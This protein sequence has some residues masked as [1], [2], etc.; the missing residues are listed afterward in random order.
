MLE[1]L[2]VLDVKLQIIEIKLN[3]VKEASLVTRPGSQCFKTLHSLGPSLILK[4]PIGLFPNDHLT[5]I[6]ILFTMIG[7][8][9]LKILFLLRTS[10]IELAPGHKLTLVRI[11][12]VNMANKLFQVKHLILVTTFSNT[13]NLAN[14][15]PDEKFPLNYIVRTKDNYVYV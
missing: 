6:Y 12:F 3:G 13:V 14:S 11:S 8:G 1:A 15:V 10:K 9:L 7:L 4:A 2:Q 5:S